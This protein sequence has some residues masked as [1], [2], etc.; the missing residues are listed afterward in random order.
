MQEL[1]GVGCFNWSKVSTLKQA[2]LLFDV[3]NILDIDDLLNDQSRAAF[4][5][6]AADIDF[7]MDKTVVCG[8]SV[9]EIPNDFSDAI[10]IDGVFESLTRGGAPPP[11]TKLY[12]LSAIFDDCNS[13]LMASYLTTI[14]DTV[15]I[16]RLPF[17]MPAAHG[18]TFSTSRGRCVT[19]NGHSGAFYPRWGRSS[20]P[21]PRFGMISN[22]H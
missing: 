11:G 16:C 13:R 4:P 19:S 14:I 1:H 22:G 2:A 9:L 10:D 8:T 7:L 5:H 20:R 17:L 21:S 3:L 18:R 12:P 15:P 6:V